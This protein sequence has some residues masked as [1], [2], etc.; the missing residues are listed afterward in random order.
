[1]AIFAMDD[2]RL[3]GGRQD[4]ADGHS[5]G[6][7]RR[8]KYIIHYVIRGK[9][10]FRCGGHTYALRAGE[11][12]L[13]RPLVETFY[14][15]DMDDPWEYTWVDFSGSDFMPL[16]DRVRFSRGDCIMGPIPPERILP[17][18]DRLTD[19]FAY[20][21]AHHAEW[22]GNMGL[23]MA[24]LGVYVDVGLEDPGISR[25]T[26]YFAAACRLIWHSYH[27]QDFNLDELCRELNISRVTLY[28]SFREAGAGSPGQYL[29]QYRLNE[30]K[31]Y[32]CSGISV[33]NAALSCGFSD[34]L[35]FSR[36]FRRMEG[37]SPREFVK[38]WEKGLAESD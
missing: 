33:K 12:F 3:Y 5:W 8:S 19:S 30:A 22:Y 29:L 20:G 9:G 13:I 1:M 34:P 18:F 16:L 32:M 25:D 27:R 38:A 2:A 21:G 36:A 35:Y 17:F 28:R 6:P 37:V 7:C 4:C 31:H 15:P 26:A 23:L 14:Y 24:I 10:F 11:S